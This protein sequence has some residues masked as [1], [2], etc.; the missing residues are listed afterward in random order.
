MNT[1]AIP[2]NT[3]ALAVN[4][5]RDQD[6]T[7][8]TLLVT[9]IMLMFFAG[10]SQ[11]VGV[12]SLCLG[13]LGILSKKVR[14]SM[15]FWGLLLALITTYNITYWYHIDNHKY[16][17]MYWVLAVFISRTVQDES[18]ASA[19]LRTNAQYLLAFCMIFAVMSKYMA[20]DYLDGTYFTDAMLLDT[21]FNDVANYF[22]QVTPGDLATNYAAKA[23]VMKDLH[24]EGT[25]A[26]A[27]TPL[28]NKL[29]QFMTWW[30]FGIEAL[31]G[32]LFLLPYSKRVSM[33]RNG[34][35][36]FFGLTT[37]AV[38]RIIGFGWILLVL[39]IAQ[40]RQEEK[41][42]RLW[43]IALFSLLQIYTIP[44][45]VIVEQLKSIFN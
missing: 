41:Q 18:T 39:G 25:T 44:F 6:A 14:T 20:P 8:I 7:D 15:W 32:L 33:A 3:F 23:K 21:R 12:P 37:Y 19:V 11:V 34:L 22:G 35:L 30:A 13:V 42:T 17:I 36:L 40:T 1:V 9:V 10:A 4:E 16:L 43:Y 45:G 5:L 31:M 29:A 38:P 27:T 2:S 28:I 26:L 24:F